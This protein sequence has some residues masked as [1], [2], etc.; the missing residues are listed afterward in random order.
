MN[1][2]SKVFNLIYEI[3]VYVP[4]ILCFIMSYFIIEGYINYDFYL[5]PGRGSSNIV[6]ITLYEYPLIYKSLM[7]MFI[8]IFTISFI[9]VIKGILKYFKKT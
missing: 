7:V 5:S 2:N 9:L 8:S 1:R 6:K 3:D 4:L